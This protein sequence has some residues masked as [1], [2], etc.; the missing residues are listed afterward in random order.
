[1]AD[2]AEYLPFDST[3]SQ[4][5]PLRV[6]NDFPRLWAQTNRAAITNGSDLLPVCT[7]SVFSPASI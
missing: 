1:M 6:H 5:S 4:G 2:F 7:L 3:L